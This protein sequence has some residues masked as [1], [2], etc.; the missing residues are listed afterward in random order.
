LEIRDEDNLMNEINNI[1]EEEK[2]ENNKIR[3]EL[4]NKL[5]TNNSE[6]LK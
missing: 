6:K 3:K 4:L 5:I 1:Y 2:T